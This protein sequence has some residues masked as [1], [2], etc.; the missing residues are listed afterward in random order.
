MAGV[1]VFG[2]AF[3]FGF[4]AV[5]GGSVGAAVMTTASVGTGVANVASAA[6][7]VTIDVVVGASGCI[8]GG[9]RQ[10]AHHHRLDRLDLGGTD[11]WLVVAQAESDWH[12]QQ[13]GSYQHADAGQQRVANVR[14]GHR[15]GAIGAEHRDHAG[16]AMR[17]GADLRSLQLTSRLVL[18]ESPGIVGVVVLHGE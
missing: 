13:D 11:A 12:Q 18:P 2:T 17:P 5:V 10:F 15:P 6:V 16:L 4:A 8:G 9:R 1:V 7:V 3:F 14:L